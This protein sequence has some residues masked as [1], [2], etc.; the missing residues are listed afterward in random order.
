MN[1]ARGGC[2]NL[3][4]VINI[5]IFVI[6]RTTLSCRKYVYPLI[7]P[8]ELNQAIASQVA[9]LTVVYVL[10]LAFNNLCLLYVEVTFY[11]VRHFLAQLIL[12]HEFHLY[13]ELILYLTITIGCPIIDDSFYN[14]FHM[15]FIKTSNIRTRFNRLFHRLYWIRVG[16]IRGN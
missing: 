2:H 9:P 16:I 7:P 4:V 10:M 1:W 12:N 3:D 14:I 15:V 11:Q 13:I 6:N 5:R 8:F